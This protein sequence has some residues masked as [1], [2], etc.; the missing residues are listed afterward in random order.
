MGMHAD[1]E[2]SER[3][4]QGN[5]GPRLGTQLAQHGRPINALE[6]DPMP[7]AN[8]DHATSGRDGESSCMDD[9]ADICLLLHRGQRPPCVKELE[10]LV[11]VPPIDVCCAPP[12]NKRCSG[13][14]CGH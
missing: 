14:V 5:R 6:E 2:V 10:N 7:V 3:V 13:D 9:L 12:P 1:M 8:L 4:Q 11:V